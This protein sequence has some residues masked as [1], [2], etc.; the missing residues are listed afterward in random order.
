[1][2]CSESLAPQP[3]SIPDVDVG[4]NDGAALVHILDS[5]KSHPVKIFMLPMR[6]IVALRN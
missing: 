2:E 6:T 4:I 3:D 5:K 1:M